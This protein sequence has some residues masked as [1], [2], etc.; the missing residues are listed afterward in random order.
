MLK[1]SGVMLLSQALGIGVLFVSVPVII[2]RLGLVGYGVWESLL[3]VSMTVMVLQSAVSSTVLWRISTCYGLQ[4]VQSA[5]RVVR[6]SV[7]AAL[8][9]A[10]VFSPVVWIA[11]EGLLSFLQVPERWMAEAAW[12]L[13]ALVVVLFLGGVNQALLAMITGCQRAGLAALIQSIGIVC[14]HLAAIA[15]LVSGGGL[16]ALLCGHVVGLIATFIMCY[17][18]ATAMCGPLSLRPLWPD[19]DEL[20][21]IAPFAG[22]LLISQLALV[23]RDQT[24]KIVLA[25]VDSPTAAGCFSMAQRFTAPLMQLGTALCVPL[26]AAVGAVCARQD[27]NSVHQLYSRLTHW[28]SVLTGMLAFVIC[29]LRGPLFV[30]WLGSD[31]PAAHLFLPLQMCGA[32]F[33]VMFT[34]AGVALAKGTGRPGLETRYALLTLILILVSKPLLVFGFGAWA[35][36]LSSTLSWCAG[37]ALFLVLVHRHLGV[38]KWVAARSAGIFAVSVLAC[39]AC[40]KLT[41]LLPFAVHSRPSA[42]IALAGL[43]PL[44]AAF[45]LGLLATLRLIRV[46]FFSAAGLRILGRRPRSSLYE[47]ARADSLR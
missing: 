42:A 17:S 45:Y 32:A 37:G 24:D 34:A 15:V 43:C 41:N 11:R 7:A 4:D 2:A 20:R 19:R 33:A 16:A 3:A 26:T 28:L 18:L 10:G 44:L 8:F 14:T 46:D 25:S 5:Q 36:V 27:W 12:L 1:N 13:P 39:I 40:W 29:T 6:I 47:I 21:A 9:L 30:L 31:Q 22:L 23:L 38:P 35:T